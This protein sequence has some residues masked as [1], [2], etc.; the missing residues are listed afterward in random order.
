[1]TVPKHV[2]VITGAS[3]GIG[4]ELARQMARQHGAQVGLV[5]AA[6]SADKLEAV[7]EACRSHGAHTLVQALDLRQQ[8]ACRQLIH[9]TLAHWGHLDTLVNN[10]GVSAH[11]LFDEVPADQVGWYEELMTINF[12]ATLWCTH[13]ALPHLLA[14]RGRVVAVSSLAGLVGVPGRTAYSASKFAVGGFC[15]ALRTEVEP[16]GVSVTVA[17]PGVVATQIRQPPLGLCLICRCRGRVGCVEAGGNFGWPLWLGAMS[18]LIRA[19]IQICAEVGFWGKLRIFL[20]KLLMHILNSMIHG[21]LLFQLTQS[22][23]FEVV[24]N[25]SLP[26]DEGVG[27]FDYRKNILKCT[28]IAIFWYLHI[29]YKKAWQ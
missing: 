28:W 5:L 10:A 19:E 6:R 24:A 27:K 25:Y 22:E 14:R 9:A 12:W 11:A 17:Y 8:A 3:D 13:E 23:K 18:S 26:Q 2:V 7:A 20:C 29:R 21:E 4:A 15:E 16:R 1:M